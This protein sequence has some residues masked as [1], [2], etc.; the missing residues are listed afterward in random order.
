M[1]LALSFINQ[2]TK[3]KVQLGGWMPSV[4]NPLQIATWNMESDTQN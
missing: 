3:H 2:E 1:D 4:L